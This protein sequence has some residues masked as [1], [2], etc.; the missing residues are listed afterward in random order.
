MT[1]KYTTIN[2]TTIKPYKNTTKSIFF[3]A[4]DFWLMMIKI[5]LLN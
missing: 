1:I 5:C 4:A 3:T 2:I